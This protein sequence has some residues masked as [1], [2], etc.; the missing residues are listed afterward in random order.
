MA[1]PRLARAASGA[2]RALAYVAVAALML[3]A[4]GTVA[5]I[6]MRYVFARPIR[7]FVNIAS[8]AGAVMLAA[9]FPHVLASRGNIAID[10]LGNWL[11]ASASRWLDR[12]AAL[13]S[14]AFFS[15]MAWQYWR[16]SAGLKD[17]GQTIPVLRWPAWPW[18]AAVAFFVLVAAV[19]ALLTLNVAHEKDAA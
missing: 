9:C 4:L 13:V 19:T 15:V 7:G 12:F 14:T 1:E 18:W 10:A 6:V 11:G 16:F 3:L 2:A 5:D 17:D 8:L